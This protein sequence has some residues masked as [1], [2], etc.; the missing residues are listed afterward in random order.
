MDSSSIWGWDPQSAGWWEVGG[1][2][3]SAPTLASNG[4]HVYLVDK[5]SNQ[6]RS[7]KQF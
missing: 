4:T 3:P 2:T 1:A 7:R 5:R 6:N